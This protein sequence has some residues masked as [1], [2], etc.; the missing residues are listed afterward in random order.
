VWLNFAK[1]SGITNEIWIQME[2]IYN[3]IEK[4]I[5]YML[6]YPEKFGIKNNL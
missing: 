2:E 6:N 5:G 4:L 1:D 3:E